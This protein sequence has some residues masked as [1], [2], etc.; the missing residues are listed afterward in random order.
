MG[1]AIRQH[2]S[3]LVRY[4]VC[5]A[6][7]SWI[8]WNTEW[9]E[10]IRA[11]RQADP[12]LLL[13]SVAVFA[14]APVLIAIRLKLLLDVHQVRLS[15]WQAVKVTFAGN[16]IINA[17]PLGT[18]G[19]DSVKAFYIARDTPF[20]HEAVTVVFFDRVIGVLGLV[21]MSGIVLLLDWHNPA[22]RSW[23]RPI[24][25]LVLLVVVGGG[26]YFS[27][28]TRKLLHL[29]QLLARL[30]LG[31]HLQRIDR[32]VFEF[33]NRPGRVLLC[34]VLTNILQVN[35]IVSLFLA[36]WSLGV[37]DPQ[38][39]P[40]A[41][42]PVY[43]AYVPICYLAGALPIGVMEGGFQQLLH[44]AAGFGTLEAALSLSLFGRF[45]QL[46]WALPGG[47]IVLRSRPRAE[48]VAAMEASPEVVPI[49]GEPTPNT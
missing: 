17:L 9:S 43:L 12:T 27:N 1:L 20:K 42:L 2:A 10:L 30:P 34:L 24:G 47:L 21:L 28:W 16:F 13:L 3:A 23:G 18:T 48:D 40:W 38:T 39:S 41:S 19:G 29:D 45:I 15:V 37:I 26:L 49:P 25:V 4:A 5:A 32:A 35:S 44:G 22:F 6:A 14:P 46:V 7:L 36:G 11:W 31:S 33:R 8:A